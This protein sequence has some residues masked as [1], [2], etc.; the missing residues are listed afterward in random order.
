[1]GEKEAKVLD[2]AIFAIH[3]PLQGNQ[4]ETRDIKTIPKYVRPVRCTPL[5]AVL[6][7]VYGFM[8]VFEQAT[9]NEKPNY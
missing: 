1:M 5:V 6:E 2:D 8:R 4:K 3:R 7:N 9:W